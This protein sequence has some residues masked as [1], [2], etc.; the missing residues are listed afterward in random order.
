MRALFVINVPSIAQNSTSSKRT[1]E[2]A[3]LELKIA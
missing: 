3:R 2:Q 1:D